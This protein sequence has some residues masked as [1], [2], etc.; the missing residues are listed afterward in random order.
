MRQLVYK[1]LTFFCLLFL[2]FLHQSIAQTK[3]VT[4]KVS[5]DKGNP[6]SGATVVARGFRAGTSTDSSGNFSLTMP[7]AAKTLRI[8]SIG[9][10]TI[11]VGMGSGSN[12]SVTIRSEGTSLNDGVVVGYGTARR[13][14]VTGAVSSISSKDFNQGIITTP[15]D[16]V[17]GKVPGLVITK[18]DGDP[19]SNPIIRLRGQTSLLGSQTPLLVVDGV[20]LDNY[21]VLSSIPTADIVT[22]DFLKDASAA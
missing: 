19:N 10:S 22:F 3:T 7:G 6:V 4:G 5:D 14:D 15:M 21:E 2:F 11:E 18:P 13:K 12:I 9:F 17:Q 16:A 8:S 20:I 1:K